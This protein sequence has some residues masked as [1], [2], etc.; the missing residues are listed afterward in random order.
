ML[1]ILISKRCNVMLVEA[2]PFT[3]STLILLLYFFAFF[4]HMWL[5]DAIAVIGCLVLC[6]FFLKIRNKAACFQDIK[7]SILQPSFILFTI[8]SIVGILLL[9]SRGVRTW[10]ELNFWAVDVKSL[11]YLQG[12]ASKGF[13]CSPLYGDYPPASQLVEAWFT[14]LFGKYDEGLTLSA[15]FLVIQIY[16]FPVISRL[17]KIK[18]ICILAGMWMFFVF[19]FGPDI[20]ND[21]S[22]DVLMA[23]V[24]GS[25]LVFAFN[26]KSKQWIS[27][28]SMSLLLAVLV[29]TKSIGIQ[30]S[31][32]AI[33]FIIGIDIVREK[34]INRKWACCIVFPIAIY[35]S[36]I[37]FCK[38]FER[39]TYLV[40][41]LNTAVQGQKEDLLVQYGKKL[42]ITFSRALFLKQQNSIF[43]IGVSVFVCF[44]L[45]LIF[46][47]ILYKIKALNKSEFRFIFGF[48]F[49]CGVIEYGILLFSV[50]TMFIDEYENYLNVEHMVMLLRRYGCPYLIGSLMLI[51]SIWFKTNLTGILKNKSLIGLSEKISIER[52]IWIPIIILSILISPISLQW[53]RYVS[54]RNDESWIEQN[55]AEV[56]PELKPVFDSIDT[57]RNKNEE[58][59]LFVLDENASWCTFDNQVYIR[60]YASPLATDVNYMNNCETESFNQILMDNK[61][62]AICFATEN[63]NWSM[64]DIMKL[65]ESFKPYKI[66][67]LDELN[68]E[69]M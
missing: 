37:I 56:K 18:D 53:E 14:H 19:S 50:E 12:F 28:I 11:F 35:E 16:F 10:D 48:V 34:K 63:I 62:T 44:L 41:S 20:M 43:G 51:L 22:A 21:R 60:Y 67:Y 1:N 57:V 42:A 5:V 47:L 46:V 32:F 7:K 27:Y 24:F 17:P 25:I 23:F 66:Y 33:I 54:Y 49:T 8:V 13:N 29:L 31:I 55:I 36:W 30:W 59:V 68:S 6:I 2:Q 4:N 26:N 3:F 39:T 69:S 9:A 15:Y 58:K 52:I 65:P 61:Y 38:V 40:T 64:L 45:I